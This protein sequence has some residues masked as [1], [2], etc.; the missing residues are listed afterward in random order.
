MKYLLCFLFANCVQ[1]NC[2]LFPIDAKEGNDSL[3]YYIASTPE[4]KQVALD[5]FNTELLQ[6]NNPGDTIVAYCAPA[7][8]EYT[9]ENYHCVDRVA[10]PIDEP[11]RFV[12]QHDADENNLGYWTD[13][14]EWVPYD[15]PCPNNET[16]C[17][18][19]HIVERDVLGNFH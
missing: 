19:A 13:T 14:G 2:I 10:I 6:K 1:A 4:A 11:G 3:L 15:H 5:S 18:D 12:C 9:T 8:K 17:E 7:V 16:E